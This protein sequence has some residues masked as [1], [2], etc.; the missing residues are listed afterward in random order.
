MAGI[1]DSKTRHIDF[2][3]TEEGKRQA[4]QSEL[5]IKFASF[6]DQ[7]TFYEVSGANEPN[8]AES[9]ANRLYF[10]ASSKFQDRIVV[11]T[12]NRGSIIRFRSKDF[13]ID[14][15]SVIT[16]SFT[17]SANMSDAAASTIILSGA[18]IPLNADNIVESIAD[19]LTDL[20][21]IRTDD[22]FSADKGF[23]ISHDNYVFSITD[24]QPFN[25]LDSVGNAVQI[26]DT[27]NIQNIEKIHQDAKFKHLPNFQFMPPRNQPE[28]GTTAG[29]LLGSYLQ[30]SQSP[31]VTIQD[32][33]KRLEGKEKLELTFPKT[34]RDNNLM[35]QVYEFNT[36]GA[37]GIPVVN[38]IKKL[39]IVDYGE[40]PD[41]DPLSPGKRVFFLGKYVNDANTGI[42]TFINIF[43]I[44]FD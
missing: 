40:F 41:E 19:N 43:T 29:R 15:T 34:S 30:F 16:G 21:I 3:F 11:E 39:S 33:E 5:D 37:G 20:R 28:P 14:E 26:N 2:M 6:T 25:Y 27:E 42:T 24:N 32:L 13:E 7:H 31:I 38:T 4:A 8:V 1:L 35:A 22:P 17:K 10:E 9:A 18:D 12:D 44:I 23:E 36:T